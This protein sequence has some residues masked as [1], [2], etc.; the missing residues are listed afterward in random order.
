MCKFESQI[1]RSGSG[2]NSKVFS[3]GRVYM[4]LCHINVQVMFIIF[5]FVTNCA[6]IFIHKQEQK[7]LVCF[8]IFLIFLFTCFFSQFFVCFPASFIIKLHKNIKIYIYKFNFTFL[9]YTKMLV[10]AGQWRD[11]L[12]W[13]IWGNQWH[14]IGKTFWN[15]LG[16]AGFPVNDSWICVFEKKRQ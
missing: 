5:I 14:D 12:G 9:L 6:N 4:C 10:I 11:Q 7:S 13:N 2:S 8:F 15:L 1:K 16:N 3:S